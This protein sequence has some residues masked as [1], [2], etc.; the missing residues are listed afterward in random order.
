MDWMGHSKEL[1]GIYNNCKALSWSQLERCDY[2]LI[3]C[4]GT[5]FRV[6]PKATHYFGYIMIKHPSE[7][8]KF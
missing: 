3:K 2:H 7:D 5:E 8:V 6:G 4:K 1:E